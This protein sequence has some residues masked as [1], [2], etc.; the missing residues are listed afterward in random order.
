M[1]CDRLVAMRLRSALLYLLPATLLACSH[2]EPFSAYSNDSDQ[3]FNS[4]NIPIRLT[5]NQGKDI[6]AQW[7]PD[8]S[9]FLYTFQRRG[10]D[11]G[12]WCIGV[13]PATGGR[14]TRTLCPTSF[15]SRDS[16]NAWRAGALEAGGL[17]AYVR[18]ANLPNRE[19]AAT[20]ELVVT[21]WDAPE[22][23][24]FQ[25]NGPAT[26]PGTVTHGALSQLRW[27]DAGAFVYRGELFGL[28]RP[29]LSCPP[30]TVISGRDLVLVTLDN[31]ALTSTVIAGTTYASS[32]A[33]R[34]NDEVFF[35]RADD[36]R[37]FRWLRSTGAIT[38]AYDFGGQGIARGVQISG[39]RL[40]AI[41]GGNVA[42]VYHTVF[43]DSVLSDLGG[44]VHVVDLA[45]LTDGVVDQFTL[46]RYPALSPNGRRLLVESAALTPDLF[47]F[48]LP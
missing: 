30:D 27:L 42:F 41:V 16:V 24:L 8:G 35:T 1:R 7:L 14:I 32:V 48:E 2:G 25:R 19:A 43:Q 34:G 44:I 28:P 26:L 13:L 38:T 3:P 12:D 10:F 21:P 39:N 17:L 9:G 15:A 33:V 47:M 31:G 46:Y 22:Q 11:E 45:T 6:E 23:I 5:Y 20:H 36:S 40:V 4:A 29:C 18:T 37:V